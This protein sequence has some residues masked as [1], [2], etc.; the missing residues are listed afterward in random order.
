[1]DVVESEKVSIATSV[2]VHG[3]TDT[4]LD[5][6][7]VEFLNKHGRVRR[8]LRVDNPQSPIHRDVI[9]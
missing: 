3:L 1:M 2:I 7:L 4:E 8:Q 9:V 5:E 6:D